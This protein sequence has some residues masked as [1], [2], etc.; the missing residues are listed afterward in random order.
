[1]VELGHNKTDYHLARKLKAQYPM[2]R[3]Y[4]N[5]PRTTPE[6]QLIPEILVPTI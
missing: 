5:D 1:M 4:L 3:N 6:A 2:R